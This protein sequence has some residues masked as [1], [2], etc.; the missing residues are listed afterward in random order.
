MGKR[1]IPMAKI[2]NDQSRMVS[3]SKRRNGLFKKANELSVLTGTRTAVLVL[4]QAGRPYVFGSP[5][6]E[7]V[8][9]Q[10][11]SHSEE[12]IAG[13]SVATTTVSNDGQTAQSISDD[14]GDV[15]GCSSRIDVA[16]SSWSDLLEK[17]FDERESVKKLLALKEDLEEMRRRVALAM[18]LQFVQ[19]LFA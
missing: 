19:S 14:G 4:S 2:E 8:V 16:G 7:S 12:N 11:L 13:T 9:E 17:E 6:L 1:K 5:S 15:A 18:D 10:F 3:F